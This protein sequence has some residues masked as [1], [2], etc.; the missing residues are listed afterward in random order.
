[1]FSGSLSE[2][3]QSEYHQNSTS[4]NSVTY[5]STTEIAVADL[6]RRCFNKLAASIDNNLFDADVDLSTVEA[7]VNIS[8]PV[9]YVFKP[10]G[11]PECQNL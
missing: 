10:Q 4:D 1:L 2:V 11:T 6:R 9:V 3:S 8:I 5:Y 7:T